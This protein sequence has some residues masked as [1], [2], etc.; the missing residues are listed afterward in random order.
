[1]L[2]KNAIKVYYNTSSHLDYITTVF[3][4]D[5]AM[6]VR[7]KLARFQKYRI[8][9]KTADDRVIMAYNA[10]GL[11]DKAGYRNYKNKERTRC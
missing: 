6:K 8:V 2:A 3:S 4:M 7:D 11:P 10:K 9:L 5:D 1:M